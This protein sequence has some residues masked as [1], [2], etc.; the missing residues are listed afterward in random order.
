MSG[1]EQGGGNRLSGGVVGEDVSTGRI[2]VRNGAGGFEMTLR[3][4]Q[5]LVPSKATLAL[6]PP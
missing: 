4:L 2:D 5:P 1:H 6:W 3:I